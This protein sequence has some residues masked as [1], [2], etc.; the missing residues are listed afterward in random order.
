MAKRYVSIVSGEWDEPN[1]SDYLART[2]YEDHELIDIGV[3]GSG[4]GGG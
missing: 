3:L 4:L 2:V 1:A